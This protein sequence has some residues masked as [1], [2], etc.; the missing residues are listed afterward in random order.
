MKPRRSSGALA[1]IKLKT[2]KLKRADRPF[3]RDMQ[4]YG[5]SCLQRKFSDGL[6]HDPSCGPMID[7]IICRF[8]R[9]P[10]SL[11]GHEAAQTSS[12]TVC[13][14][15]IRQ[16]SSNHRAGLAAIISV[17]HIISIR[18]V[19]IMHEDST[20]PAASTGQV[21]SSQ[22]LVRQGPTVRHSE[23]S[24]HASRRLVAFLFTREDFTGPLGRSW[25]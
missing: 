7:T 23:W 9:S 1:D 14:L 16:S 11:P 15:A 17:D 12:S 24:E 3:E 13:S 22:L 19:E 8:R 25:V 10:T 5:S 20:L 2:P 18:S 4:L 6:V 21:A